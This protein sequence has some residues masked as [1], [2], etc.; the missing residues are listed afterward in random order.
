MGIIIYSDSKIFFWVAF[1]ALQKCE[2]EAHRDFVLKV[3]IPQYL[4]LGS[5][6]ITMQIR[7]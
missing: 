3:L 1:P 6:N 2:V 7:T 4:W 5:N